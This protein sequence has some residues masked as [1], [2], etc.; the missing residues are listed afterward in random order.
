MVQGQLVIV[1]VVG[2]VTVKVAL[3]VTKVVGNGQKVV[4]SVT[5]VS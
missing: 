1:K 2:A 4:N 5:T 3:L